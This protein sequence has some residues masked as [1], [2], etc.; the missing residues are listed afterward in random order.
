MQTV[1]K[2]L[3]KNHR[4]LRHLMGR[5][6]LTNKRYR[7]VLKTTQRVLAA[8]VWFEGKFL[9]PKLR[10]SPLVSSPFLKAIIHEQKLLK[11]MT[12]QLGRI[13]SGQNGKFK[14]HLFHSSRV[15]CRFY[16]RR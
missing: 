11:T 5:L 4:V 14:N 3:I 9:F 13:K 8:H 2:E 15:L 6:T 1:T 12:A 10:K 16:G 7:E